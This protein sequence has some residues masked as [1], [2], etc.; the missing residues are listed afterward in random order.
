M[1]GTSGEE[2]SGAAPAAARWSPLFLPVNPFQLLDLVMRSLVPGVAEPAERADT[3]RPETDLERAAEGRLLTREEAARRAGM[4]EEDLG[5]LCQA[6]GLAAL[7]ETSHG[8]T[9]AD[10][11]TFQEVARLLADGVID[12]DVIVSMVRPMGH[13]LSRLG[14]AQVSALTSL[15]EHPANSVAE[16]SSSAGSGV[17]R[18]VPLL[19]RLVVLAWRRHMVAA[20]SAT[21]P[22]RGLDA[23][24]APQAVGFVDIAS[25]TATSRRIDWAELASMLERFEACAFDHVAAAGGRVVKT[26]GDEVLFLAAEP[27]AAAEIALGVTE[28]A[29]TDPHLPAVHAGLAYGP[30]LERAGDVFG[31]TVNIASRVTGLARSG[32]VLIDAACRNQLEGDARFQTQRRPARP[33]RGYP[34]LVTYRLRRATPSSHG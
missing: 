7:P 29:L 2:T 1:S 12:L 27:G 16:P 4:T 19:E 30:L 11:D 28:A 13:L 24:S 21:L 3:V 5:R 20:A 8:Y 31:P 10:V 6:L 26:L 25:Y 17:E 33:V 23:R 9:E 14:S 32:S 34:H 15:A 18:L 22:V